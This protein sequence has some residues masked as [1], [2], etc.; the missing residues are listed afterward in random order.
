MEVV[1]GP[2][3]LNRILEQPIAIHID[4][5]MEPKEHILPIFPLPQDQLQRPHTIRHKR[6]LLNGHKDIM[7]GDNLLDNGLVGRLELV[8]LDSLCCKQNELI[9]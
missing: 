5:G 2:G 3:D 7:F 4:N 1:R 9:D 6:F 8:L